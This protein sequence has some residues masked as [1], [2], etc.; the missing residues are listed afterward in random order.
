MRRSTLVSLLAGLIRAAGAQAQPA[1]NAVRIGVLNDQ[2]GMYAD[3]GGATSVEAARVAV[4][5][6][7]GT[8]LGRKIENRGARPCAERRRRQPSIQRPQGAGCARADLTLFRRLLR[9]Q[10]RHSRA[11]TS[12]PCGLGHPADFGAP[13]HSVQ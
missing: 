5:D 3:F 11:P 12:S 2:S 7:G 4:E 13:Q 10:A 6:F 8:V 9:G 1:G